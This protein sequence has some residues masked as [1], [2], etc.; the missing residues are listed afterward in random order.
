MYRRECFKFLLPVIK[1]RMENLKR[2]RGDPSVVYD[3]TED[4][5]TWMIKALPNASPTQIADLVLSLVSI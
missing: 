4:L 1:E 3:E 2:K 5:I